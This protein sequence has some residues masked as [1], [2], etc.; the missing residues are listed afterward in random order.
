MKLDAAA[1]RALNILPEKGNNNKSMSIA[2]ILNRCKT[3]QVRVNHG[4]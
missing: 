4:L 2:G 3:S 1:V